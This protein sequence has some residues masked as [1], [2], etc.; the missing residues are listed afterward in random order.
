MRRT[1]RQPTITNVA[2][3]LP[4]LLSVQAI[5]GDLQFHSF[6][7]PNQLPLPRHLN[8]VVRLR[9]SKTRTSSLLNLFSCCHSYCQTTLTFISGNHMLLQGPAKGQ[10]RVRG[11]E[12]VQRE[13]TRTLQSCGMDLCGLDL[14][15]DG[16][17]RFPS[18]IL[19][20]KLLY[21]DIFMCPAHIKITSTLR[22][23]RRVVR[24]VVFAWIFIPELVSSTM[25]ST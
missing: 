7:K 12:D 9:C 16:K 15:A 11:F 8:V 13:L 6:N 24:D 1:R 18:T 5:L 19:P 17:R 22:Q 10:C 21:L 2:P 3:D 14:E 4:S 25:T 23:H 20:I